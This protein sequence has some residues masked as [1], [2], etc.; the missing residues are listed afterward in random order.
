MARLLSQTL[1][2]TTSSA[3]NSSQTFKL[4][5]LQQH[6]FSSQSG[7]AQL[8]EVDVESDGDV[9]VFGLKR[10][11]D[12]INTPDWLPFVP[13]LSYRDRVES[14]ARNHLSFLLLFEAEDRDQSPCKDRK[15]DIPG[16]AS[17][18][19]NSKKPPLFSDFLHILLP[20]LICCS[21]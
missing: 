13:G 6:Q 7:K 9:E 12:A 4:G 20:E 17:P 14:G 15:C 18:E 1:I 21:W 3:S 8:L 19:F 16:S 11:E 5:V 10:L 2:R